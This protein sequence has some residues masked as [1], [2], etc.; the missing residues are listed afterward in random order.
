MHGTDNR[1][2]HLGWVETALRHDHPDLPNLRLVAQSHYGPPDRI[3]SIEV[4]GV[5]GDRDLR[6][7]IRAEASDLLRRLGYRVE[8]EPG[9]DVYDFLPEDPA[10][11][12]DALRMLRALREAC[13][14]PEADD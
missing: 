3:A 7:K 8:L 6:R 1:A 10:S 2:E 11:A 14:P 13:R 4:L 5:R 12:H 9:R